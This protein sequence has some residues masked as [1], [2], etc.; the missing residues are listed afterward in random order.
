MVLGAGKKFK[1]VKKGP[2]K[3][4]VILWSALGPFSPYGISRSIICNITDKALPLRKLST[5]MQQIPRIVKANRGYTE[6][7]CYQKTV[8]IYDLTFHFCS[9]FIDKRD[10]TYDQMI[11]A[12]RSGKQNIVEGYVDRATSFEMALKL[13]NVARGS[14]AE[15][16]EDYLDY[17]RV[18]GMRCWCDGSQ[19]KEAMRRL[20]AEHS[21]SDFFL[22]L[23]ESRND[24]T[25]ANMILVLLYQADHLL[26]NFIQS[27]EKEFL[28]N[29]GVKERMYRARVKN[30]GC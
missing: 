28:D 1:R 5:S 26:Y 17:L 8:V 4:W 30:R 29:G 16:R 15:L 2:K 24:E 19:Q 11:Q 25:V 20:A 21:D 22:K 14:L 7:F 12:A 10:R 9:R 3:E 6:L 13:Y 27:E 18:R 23:A